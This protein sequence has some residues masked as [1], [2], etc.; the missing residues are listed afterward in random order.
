MI[1]LVLLEALCQKRDE[2]RKIDGRKD[3]LRHAADRD[4]NRTSL[5]RTAVVGKMIRNPAGCN[6]EVVPIKCIVQIELCCCQSLQMP[7]LAVCLCLIGKTDDLVGEMIDVFPSP[8]PCAAR[9]GYT[10]NELNRILPHAEEY[11]AAPKI[12][13]PILILHHK[14]AAGI[15]DAHHL[16]EA[17]RKNITPVT[18][19]HRKP[20][21]KFLHTRFLR[22]PFLD[23]TAHT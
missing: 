5:V 7:F 19:I 12:D 18:P 17:R 21:K 8:E 11:N 3:L 2:T 15:L 4:K 6:R 9:L 23:D 1:D 13:V 16:A 14:L 10:S 22:S 20:I